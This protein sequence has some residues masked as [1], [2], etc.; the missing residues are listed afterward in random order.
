MKKIFIL[1]FISFL[2]IG[3]FKNDDGPIASGLQPYYDSFLLEAESR[4]YPLSEDQLDIRMLFANIGNSNILGQCTFRNGEQDVV[5]IDRFNWKT[6]D[7]TKK[8]FVV[9]HELGHCILK[10]G[11]LD[12]VDSDGNCLSVMH[13]SV[14]LCKF[15][16]TGVNRDLYLDELFQ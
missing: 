5:E 12:A 8:E 4:N 3:C 15:D 2:F 14:D 16:F 13:S 10:R 9:F 6:F 11:H 7:E 1:S